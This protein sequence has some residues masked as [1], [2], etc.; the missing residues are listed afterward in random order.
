MHSMVRSKEQ[1]RRAQHFLPTKDVQ[2]PTT[3]SMLPVRKS[4]RPETFSVL[5]GKGRAA[6][7]RDLVSSTISSVIKVLKEEK[8]IPPE[9]KNLK[10]Y[11]KDGG[12][13]A[14][15]M[16]TLKS[17][18]S[19]NDEENIFQYGLIPLKMTNFIDENTEEVVWTN[20]VPNSAR[21]LRPIYLIREKETNEDLLKEVVHNTDEA[22]DDLNM[23]GLMVDDE[24]VE[25]DIKDT[26]KD[27]KFKKLICGLGGAACILCK[28]KVEDWTNVEKIKDGFRIDRSAADTRD[29]FNSVVDE[30]S[31]IVIKPKDFD[32]RSGVTKEPISTSDQESI[33]ITHSYINGCTWYLKLLYRSYADYQKWEEKSTVIGEPLRKARK[34]VRDAIRDAT[35][36][37]LDYV[38]SAGAK[39][40]TS[41]T[42]E[43]ARR[44]FS[45]K[46]LPIIK[47]LLSKPNNI[48]HQENMLKLHQE[49]SIV[50]RVI[51]CTR[52]IN[53]PLFQKHCEETMLN[54]AYNFPWCK[55]NHTL[56]G[57]LQHS[58]ELI[59]MNGGESLGWYSEEGLEANNKDIR[60][61]LERL[62]RKTCNNKQIEDVHHRLLER[63]DPYLIHVT[64]KYMLKKKCRICD[65][66]DHT[67]RSHLKYTTEELDALISPYLL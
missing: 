56:H 5:N 35:G 32:V 30:N 4:L 29:I 22:R 13:G 45:D 2:F 61:F 63:S 53:V 59:E 9:G 50:F 28:S 43:Q 3:D 62:S 41:T 18:V 49:L 42:G 47:E 33:T 34:L 55:L 67:S 14:G 60:K 48:K 38:N 65:N 16:P 12:D 58:C 19:V 15:Q 25:V 27:L 20:P 10:L 57:A 8:L 31:N 46:S 39:T 54:M 52:K 36:L 66:K 24:K 17:K 11:L 6:S 7:Y 23:N 64:S 21:S 44:F 40:G 51:S 1:T 26:M 37:K